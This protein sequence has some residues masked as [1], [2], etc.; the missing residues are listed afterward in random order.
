MSDCSIVPSEEDKENYFTERFRNKRKGNVAIITIG[1][2][3]SG[4]TTVKKIR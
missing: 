2:P 3:G 1:G 4:K